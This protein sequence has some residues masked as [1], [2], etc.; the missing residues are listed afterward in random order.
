MSEETREELEWYATPGALTDVGAH[1]ER[2]ADLPSD[3]AGLCGVVQGL[4]LHGHLGALYG[5]EIDD[6]RRETELNLRSADERLAR[7]LGA[8]RRP[9]TE[10]RAPEHRQLGTCRDFALLLCSFLR[11]QGRAA[12]A[13]CGFGG[14]FVHGRFEDHWVCEVWDGTDE[15]WRLV[16][17]QIDDVQRRHFGPGN[18]L[19]VT[20]DE[21]VVGGEAWA[22]CRAGRLDPARFGLTSIGE[23]GLWFV[24]GDFVRDVASLNKVEL[25]PWDCWGVMLQNGGGEELFPLGPAELIARLPSDDLAELDRVAPLASGVV[26]VAGLRRCYEGTRWRVPSSHPAFGAARI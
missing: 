20:R 14:Y 21:F 2:L 10:P 5:I 7:L 15:R 3:L 16:D 19:D 8:E 4:L 6:A 17:A 12:R 9:L 23:S 26:D 25:L 13:R 11:W 18:S 24:C 1:E 22:G